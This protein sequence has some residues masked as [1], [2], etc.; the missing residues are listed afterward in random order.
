[1]KFPNKIHNTEEH[2]RNLDYAINESSIVALTDTKGII[3]FV[4]NK[5]CEISK[6]SENELIGETH[7]ILN[8]GYHSRDFFKELWKTIGRGEVWNGEIKNKA[9]DGSFYWVET[10]IVPFLD[11]QKKPYQYM[12]IRKDITDRKSLHEQIETERSKAMYSEKMAALGEMAAG[13]AHELGNP[14]GA[15]RG[16]IEL[17]QMQIDDGKLDAEYA[18]DIC[19][20][21]LNLTDKMSKIIRGLRA[22]SRDGSKDPFSQVH[23]KDLISGVIEFSTEKFR[24]LGVKVKMISDESSNPV[25]QAREAEIGQVI[26]NLLSNACDATKS[27]DEGKRFIEIELVDRT[28][29]IE[30]QVRDSGPG[31]DKEKLDKAFEPYFTTKPVGQGTGLGLSISRTIVSSH[32]GDLSYNYGAEMTE[33]VVKLPKAQAKSN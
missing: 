30:I 16:R 14:L 24:K 13:I 9:K 25:I 12:A 3:T 6:Y 27:V 10:T 18:N 17:L 8:S 22:Y 1:M 5:F 2:L 4:N 31:I 26:V 7:G 20:K 11:D 15:L 28:D 33:F 32:S 19:N 23:I 21:V 29:E